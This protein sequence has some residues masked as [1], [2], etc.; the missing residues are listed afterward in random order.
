MQAMSVFDI[1]RLLTTSN[2]IEN[3]GLR[4]LHDRKGIISV[5]FALVVPV[6]LALIF[7]IV[8]GANLYRVHSEMSAAARDGTR[9]LAL[10][11]MEEAAVVALVKDR[12]GNVTGAPVDVVVRHT[13]VGEDDKDVT[14]EVSVNIPDALLFNFFDKSSADLGDQHE[15]SGESG[16]SEDDDEAPSGDGMIMTASATMLQE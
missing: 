7:T 13:D 9:R 6:F 16:E 3:R 8:E 1:S 12:V 15:A 10:G 14:M 5:E 4:L 11:A 2:R